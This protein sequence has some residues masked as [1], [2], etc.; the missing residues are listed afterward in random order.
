MNDEELEQCEIC[1]VWYDEQQECSHYESYFNNERSYYRDTMEF[2]SHFCH[3]CL[4]DIVEEG[5][6]KYNGKLWYDL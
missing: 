4:I 2:G 3:D 5:L 1:D 6:E